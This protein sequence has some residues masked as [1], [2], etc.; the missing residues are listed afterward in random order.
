LKDL[1]Q[2]LSSVGLRR[3]YA[4]VH[5]EHIRKQDNDTQK[6]KENTS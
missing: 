3:P 5:S 2:E 4:N 6:S 1:I